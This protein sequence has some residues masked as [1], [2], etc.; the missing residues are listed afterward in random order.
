MFTHK[1]DI[2]DVCIFYQLLFWYQK[3]VY[4]QVFIHLNGR[5]K[6]MKNN[7]N[8]EKNMMFEGFYLHNVSVCTVHLC[9]YIYTHVYIFSSMV[10]ERLE[11]K[12]DHV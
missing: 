3:Q 9:I 2:T 10:F 8:G 5:N 11:V 1:V 4:N 7:V 12:V 6:K